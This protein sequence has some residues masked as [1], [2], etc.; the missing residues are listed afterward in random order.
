MNLPRCLPL[1]T[2]T[3]PPFGCLASK[4]CMEHIHDNIKYTYPVLKHNHQHF[5][6]LS[7]K[8]STHAMIESGFKSR[9][10]PKAFFP[11][12]FD[13]S[14][15]SCDHT[16]GINIKTSATK[17]TPS[18]M[19]VRSVW[20]LRN[21]NQLFATDVAHR[22]DMVLKPHVCDGYIGNFDNCVYA[23]YPIPC[24]ISP[25][26]IPGPGSLQTKIH[27]V[28]VKMWIILAW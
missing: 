17:M 1:S 13:T 14:A 4:H 6:P 11:V 9:A 22:Y 16:I 25:T 2:K 15:W 8:T 18:A 27:G 21:F 20:D 3:Y 12:Q 19:L 10:M 23:T 7:C 5:N 28:L 24:M 26:F